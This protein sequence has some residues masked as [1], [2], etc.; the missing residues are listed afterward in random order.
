MNFLI[1]VGITGTPAYQAKKL[2]KMEGLVRSLFFSVTT[3]CSLGL[4]RNIG[5]GCSKSKSLG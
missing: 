3:T 5:D 1:S 4:Q 2:G